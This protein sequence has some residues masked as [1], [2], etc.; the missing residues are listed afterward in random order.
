MDKQTKK[1]SSPII[2]MPKTNYQKALDYYGLADKNSRQVAARFNYTPTYK[3]K[4]SGITKTKQVG[5]DNPVFSKKVEEYILEKW[6]NDTKEYEGIYRYK[7]RIYNK[8]TKKT[9][10]IDKQFSVIGTKDELLLN[11]LNKYERLKDKYNRE[12]DA[13]LSSFD[14]NLE[15]VELIDIKQGKGILVANRSVETTASGGQRKVGRRGHKGNM[16][17]RFAGN[18]LLLSGKTNQEWD[19]K[20]GTCVFDYLYW[21]FKDCNGF[22]KELGSTFRGKE[23]SK[24]DAYEWLNTLFKSTLI[25]EQNPLEQGVSVYQLEKFCDYFNISMYAFDKDDEMIEWYRPIQ[26]IK[27]FEDETEAEGKKQKKGRTAL[28]FVYYNQHFNPIEDTREQNKKKSFATNNGLN[29]KS[30][31]I[32]VYKTAEDVIERQVISPDLDY[33]IAEQTNMEETRKLITEKKLTDNGFNNISMGNKMAM[34]LLR[35]NN[36]VLP[37]TMK[38]GTID[39]EENT[40]TRIIYDDKII[41]TEP[42]KYY[43]KD[44]VKVDIIVKKYLEEY[45]DRTFQGE[46]YISI[47]NEIWT[48]MYPFTIREAPFNSRPNTEVLNALNADKVKYR[49]HLG[50]MK[51]E[52]L[53]YAM[54]KDNE[55]RPI[56]K[57]LKN[58]KAIAVDISKCYA[59]C[60]YNQ[61]E[62][63]IVLSGKETLEAYDGK[64]LTLGLYFIETDD[65]SLF[66]KSNWY[67]R[68]I[69]YTAR[70]ERIPFR[71]T[72]QIRCLEPEWK[73]EK[74]EYDEDGNETS[75]IKLNNRNLFKPYCDSVIEL[76]EMNEDFT[77]TKLILN[78]LTGY[79]GKTNAKIKKAYISNNLEDVWEDWLIPE[80]SDNPE[81]DAFVYPIKDGDDKL[82]VYGWE[83]QSE[84]VS[85][86]LPMYIQ[87]LDWANVALYEMIKAVGGECIYRK[88]DAIVSIGGKL[89][90]DNIMKFPC[91]FIQTF[92]KYRIEENAENFFYETLM[93]VNRN[94]E[95]PKLYG[96]W[97]WYDYNDS[98]DWKSIIDKATEKGGMMITGR[99][100]TGKSYVIQEAIKNNII[101]DD[102]KTRLAPTNRAA[103]NINGI[104]IHKALAIN[105]NGKTNPKSMLYYANKKYV[106]VDEISMISSNIWTYLMRLK[107]K[108]PH[109]IF[110]LMGDYRQ[111]PPIEDGKEIDYFNHS[112][113]K[114]LTN[115][116]RCELSKPQRYDMPL[117]NWLENF[118]EEGIVGSDISKKKLSI[119]NILYRK[120]ICYMNKTRKQINQDCM[121]HIL[122]EMNYVPVFLPID[123]KIIE[124]NP[125]ADD[126]YIYKGLPVMAVKTCSE[127]EIINSEEFWVKEVS[128][129][130][131]TITLYRDEDPDGE[132]LVVEFKEYHKN[133]VV[134]Y[135]ATTHKSQGATIEKDI[136]IWDWWAMLKDRKLGY[137][138]VSR[139]KSCEQITI[140]SLIDMTPDDDEDYFEPPDDNY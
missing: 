73:Y 103:R 48:A 11:A 122:S 7:F 72:H 64:P 70:A 3:I 135:A 127:M 140:A 62:N 56:K 81:T 19:M 31:D 46:T 114:H 133:F 98:S 131:Q 29:I 17:M 119:E 82:Y 111:C 115:C 41:L 20:Q 75:S 120:N 4:K 89:P 50:L 59:D 137:T 57:L 84:Y 30:N 67:S 60:I 95:T 26:Q 15:P 5:V 16:K 102:P 25:D 77:L 18:H 88:T 125:Y 61:R 108:Y 97:N 52:Y 92:G 86:C 45:C 43:D 90:K 93:N 118:Y 47:M 105:N 113:T 126:A 39:V 110:I 91:S 107:Q 54:E 51:E 79:L 40:I 42:V 44:K 121:R 1:Q 117:W 36:W 8:T 28:F 80:V 104:T 109:L 123:E 14:I 76:T 2:S 116:N 134:N 71:I 38:A 99:A 10:T 12:S 34:E 55:E 130:E 96:D 22:K 69:I 124:T 100:G 27:E 58:K 53:K 132:V 24:A 33:Y 85:N 37:A 63:F 136:N 13:D 129:S 139:A 78:S 138:A 101:P 66:H 9:N 6:K 32:E 112:Y 106:I 94:A 23:V 35:Q 21:R 74:Y 83:T 65:M 49:T 128:S 87:I 68:E